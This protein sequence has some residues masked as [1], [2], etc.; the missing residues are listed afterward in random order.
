MMVIVYFSTQQLLIVYKLLIISNEFNI[1]F[2]IFAIL[3]EVLNTG[4]D[5]HS[6]GTIF[7]FLCCS[8]VHPEEYE[9]RLLKFLFEKVFIN[10]NQTLNELLLTPIPSSPEAYSYERH[11]SFELVQTTDTLQNL[12]IQPLTTPDMEQMFIERTAL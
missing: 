9:K 3:N 1:P 10:S 12:A 11:E 7:P 8:V 5:L 2:K 6:I 4:N